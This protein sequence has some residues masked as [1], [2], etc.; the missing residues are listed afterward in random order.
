MCIL[1]KVTGC[2][3]G[4]L[5]N[6]LGSE[7]VNRLNLQQLHGAADLLRKDLN[8]LSYASFAAGHEAVEVCATDEGELGAHRESCDDIGTVHDARVHS[9]VEVLA[10]L[11]DNLGNEV[12]GHGSAIELSTAVVGQDDAVNTKVCELL[13]V[14]NVLNTLDHELA[15]PD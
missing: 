4:E 15:W 9:D 7:F 5:S 14:F 6:M 3:A 10:H 11:A 2:E 8:G 13:G 1:G 12:E